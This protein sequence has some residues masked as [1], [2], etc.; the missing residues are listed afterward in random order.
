[1]N[2]PTHLLIVQWTVVPSKREGG[3]NPYKQITESTSL[4]CNVALFWLP[5][6]LLTL[7]APPK[8]KQQPVNSS[9]AAKSMKAK[10]PFGSEESA[11]SWE[12]WTLRE[13]AM[14]RTKRRSAIDRDAENTKGFW[15]WG[16]LVFFDR[17]KRKRMV[18]AGGSRGGGLMKVTVGRWRTHLRPT[19]VGHIPNSFSPDLS[20]V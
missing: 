1:M 2:G 13:E 17:E 11:S 6:L 19:W 14:E 15:I 20:Y 4:S 9:E 12:A 10:S 3:I 5:N 16:N 18:P 7:A 8:P